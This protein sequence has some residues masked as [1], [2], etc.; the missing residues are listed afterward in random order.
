MKK[1]IYISSSIILIVLALVLCS[2][3]QKAIS[4]NE[5][6][7]SSK[8]VLHIENGDNSKTFEMSSLEIENKTLIEILDYKNISYELGGDSGVFESIDSLESD[9]SQFKYVTIFTNIEKDQ[10]NSATTLV[11]NYNGNVVKEIA[12]DVNKLTINT[13]TIL[14]ISLEAR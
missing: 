1:V 10:A 3:C 14:Y 2:C 4:K 13:N 5:N 6:S 11:K 7:S 9:V 8:M 12:V